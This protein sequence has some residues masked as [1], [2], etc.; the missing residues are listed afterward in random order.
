MMATNNSELK[1]DIAKLDFE[2]QR[3]NQFKMKLQNALHEISERESISEMTSV[4]DRSTIAR[5]G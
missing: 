3:Q 5:H 2:L 1:A 4:F